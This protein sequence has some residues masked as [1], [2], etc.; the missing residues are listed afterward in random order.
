[1]DR[2]YLYF[3]LSLFFVWRLFI[4]IP[5]FYSESKLSYRS[6]YEYANIKNA[7]DKYTYRILNSYHLDSW[8]NFDGLHYL[9][10]SWEGYTNNYGFFPMFPIFIK[11]L[12]SV[13]G[14]RNIFD[15][16]YFFSGFLISN[17]A[18]LISL[19]ILSKLLAFDYKRSEQKWILTL[20]LF[21]PTSFFF[22][23]IYS[24]SLF[25]LFLFLS[26][27]FSRKKNFLLA[28]VFGFM[29]TLTRFVGIC[30][31]PALIYEYHLSENKNL[32]SF[33]KSGIWF[34]PF[35]LIG[36]S[37]YNFYK[38]GDFLFFIK[39][40]GTFLNHRSVDS[41]VL[42]PQTIFRYIK[43]L[44]TTSNTYFEWYIALIEVASFIFVLL[45]L[46]LAWKKRIRLSYILFSLFAVMIP[47]STGTF[48]G[49][50]RYILVA[51]PCYI[52]LGLIKNRL[53]KFITLLIFSILLFI[54][55][56]LFL[57]GFYIS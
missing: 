30:I 41:I 4:F 40:Q 48:S 51:F 45:L 20:F 22:G 3:V 2:K 6:G 50:P 28:S 43:I 7:T 55:T 31:F 56:L 34:V 12:A 24:E 15:L 44:L 14:A 18:L 21:F 47:A 10:I 32:K 36:Y 26:F 37:F 29:L 25:L 39:A 42:F 33:I 54:L 16:S 49:I 8:A 19:I 27:Y 5:D 9:Y 35:G 17:F 23:G 53:I 11:F 1:M 46:F 57:R 38:E 52:V 13:L